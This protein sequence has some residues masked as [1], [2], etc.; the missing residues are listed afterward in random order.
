MELAEEHFGKEYEVTRRGKPYDLHC[1]H[2][3]SGAVLYVEVKGTTTAGEE[4][5]LTPNEV[6]F[7]REHSGQMALFVQSGIVVEQSEDGQ[8]TASAGIS[9]TWKPWNVDAGKLKAVGYVYTVPEAL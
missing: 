7:A 8:V 3:T 6:R 1:V 9:R 2:R 5:L 4:V